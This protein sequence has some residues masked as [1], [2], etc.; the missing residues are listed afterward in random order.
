MSNIV[1]IGPTSE[2]I[3]VAEAK[4]QLNIDALYT[5]DDTLIGAMITSARIWLEK[6]TQ[7]SFIKQQR[8]QYMDRFPIC[9]KF[10]IS[11]GPVLITGSGVTPPVIKYYDSQ[12]SQQTWD[13]N[14]YWFD[15][16]AFEPVVIAKYAWPS[17]GDRPSAVSVTYFAGFGLD[18]TSVPETIKS[19]MKMIVTH[20]YNKREVE[21]EV[22]GL[23]AKLEFGIDRMIT[24]DTRIEYTGGTERY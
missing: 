15:D 3:T 4:A 10:T 12:D 11:N 17:I 7:Q 6:R 18:A 5:D 23:L 2:P 16:K 14:S 13:T 21:T 20:L 24:F 1:T 22:N 9:G 8:V 19:T